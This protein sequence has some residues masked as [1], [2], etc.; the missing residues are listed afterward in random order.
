ML[1]SETEAVWNAIRE[2]ERSLTGFVLIGG[3]A[4]AL[5]IHH[6]YSE[7]LDLAYAGPKLPRERVQ[8][9]IDQLVSKGFKVTPNDNLA[10][11]DEATIAGED[12]LDFQQDYIVNDRVKLTFFHQE[13]DV[14]PP[15]RR[16]SHRCVSHRDSRRNLQ[17]KMPRHGPPQ[18]VSRLV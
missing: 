18:Q 4:L 1:T 9:V 8:Q 3:T 5:Q 2:Q 7:D 12:M 14:K 13:K 17:T 15:P 11:M 10:V 16:S 6:R